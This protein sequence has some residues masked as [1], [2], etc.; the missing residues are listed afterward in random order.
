MM[1]LCLPFNWITAKYQLQVLYNF[2]ITCT[3]M[4]ERELRQEHGLEDNP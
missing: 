1:I 2:P 4:V 3:E